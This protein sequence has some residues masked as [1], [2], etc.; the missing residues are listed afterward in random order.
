MRP[1]SCRASSERI[2]SVTS[3]FVRHH[4][5]N[6]VLRKVLKE[7]LGRGIAQEQVFLTCCKRPSPSRRGSVC[8]SGFGSCDVTTTSS[9]GTGRHHSPDQRTRAAYWSAPRRTPPIPRGR[10]NPIGAS[11]YSGPAYRHLQEVDSTERDA[12][13]QRR[14]CTRCRL[15]RKNNCRLNR[16]GRLEQ[17]RFHGVKPGLQEQEKR[18]FAGEVMTQIQNQTFHDS[19]R[20]RYTICERDDSGEENALDLKLQLFNNLCSLRVCLSLSRLVSGLPSCQMKGENPSDDPRRDALLHMQTPVSMETQ[21]SWSGRPAL[22]S[23]PCPPSERGDPNPASRSLRRPGRRQGSLP[24][25][26]RSCSI[27][28]IPSVQCHHDN[29]VS[30]M[31][32]SVIAANPVPCGAAP[33]KDDRRE[34]AA[35]ADW[36]PP[37]CSPAGGQRQDEVA[38]LLEEAQEQLRALAHRKQEEGAVGSGG[39]G[40]GLAAAPV[41]ARETVCF[42]NL[43]GGSAAA[44]SCNGPTQ[45]QLL[46][47]SHR[48]L[49]HPG[50]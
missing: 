29:E 5:E 34:R 11:K 24:P 42:L 35:C 19:N 32:T 12:E 8:E 7:L 45:T 1:V 31:Q 16:D 38:L 36:S 25:P 20:C 46:S 4:T 26:F 3:L 15:E 43:D 47:Q 21:S 49:G 48:D 14:S 10:L 33:C 40:G 6:L 41:E 18:K 27:P 23:G 22:R 13:A 17:H 2:A 50:Q 44:L 37:S 30:C 9:R 39:G 28:I